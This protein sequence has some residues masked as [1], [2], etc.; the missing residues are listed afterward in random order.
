[1]RIGIATTEDEILTGTIDGTIVIV[2]ALAL[3]SAG[4]L[5]HLPLRVRL[6]SQSPLPHP[7][8]KR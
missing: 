4:L 7:R 6:P 3:E 8:M 1:V 5:N 2:D